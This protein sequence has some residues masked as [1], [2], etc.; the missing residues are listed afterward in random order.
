VPG[1]EAASKG[2]ATAA[3]A[4]IGARVSGV[5]QFLECDVNVKVKAGQLCAKI[6][7]R[8]YQTIVDKNKS[9]LAE[10]QAR[11]E[12]DKAD[13]AQAKAVLDRRE[14][15]A[16]RRAISQ[17]AVDQSRKAYEQVQART[18]LGEA[19]VTELQAALH[20]AETNLDF[21]DIVAPVDGTVVTRNVE[22]GQTVASGSEAPPLFLIATDPSTPK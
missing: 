15:R 6:D 3:T 7:A 11:L 17:K 8:P 9:D 20:A 4:L 5:I 18:K 19:R 12:A 22:I 1:S 21:T 10:A 16:K 2:A 14:A 13:L